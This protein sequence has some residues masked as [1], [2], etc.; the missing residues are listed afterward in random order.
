MQ[1]FTT[2]QVSLAS[3][4]AKGTD[5]V[6]LGLADS[7]ETPT[8][9]G[10]AD[11]ART[12]TKKIAS[13]VELAT[14]LEASTKVGATTM[15]PSLDGT[16]VLLVGV[17]AGALTPETVRKAAGAAVRTAR[18]LGKKSAVKVAI[19]LGCN[20]PELV[21][22]A[23]E[24]ALL[25]SYEYGKVTAQAATQP[26]AGVTIVSTASS[27]EAKAAVA[28][29]Q[30]VAECVN[31]CREWVNAPANILYPESFA[32]S[33][34][35]LAKQTKVSV[36][37][38]DDKELQAQG[39]GGIMSV[40]KG[41]ERKPR[42]VR[43][44]YAPRGAK[45]HLVLV[46]KGI[47]FDTGG[48]NLKSADGMYT[49]KCD[50]AGAATVLAATLAIA[51]L[52]LKVKVTTY[53]CMAENMPSGIAFRPSDVLTMYGGKTVEN[54]NSDAEGRLVMADALARANEDDPDLVVDVATLTG[55]CVVALGEWY[56]G[57]MASDH[58]TA[59]HVLDAAESS[60]EGFW[61]LPIPEEIAESLKSD[62]ADLK[63]SGS[64][65][66]GALLAAAF[67]HEFVDDDTPWAHLDI[68]GTA[69]N[70][71]KP[72]GHTPLGGT[73]HGVRTLIALAR[74]MQA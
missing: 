36:T 32:D 40:G 25:G 57:L 39:Y 59:D 43:Y 66:G 23:A 67:L 56:A 45:A 64:R 3:A 22:A 10:G 68:A 24:G 47:T 2:P 54:A 15:L 33:A 13:P 51:R 27:K 41:S 20:D 70:T 74:G 12:M 31:V 30:V 26:I 49:M 5:V 55:A 53:A 18:S 72:S 73:G 44:S 11:L 38:L 71:G 63:S 48:L 58:A 60:A 62:V 9:V 35:A 21:R 65:M 16:R 6:V 69:F 19:D 7:G 50:M 17:G 1:Q 37:V 42:L 14:Q 46:G 61:H 29:A 8:L 28:D 52:G 34:A 4:P